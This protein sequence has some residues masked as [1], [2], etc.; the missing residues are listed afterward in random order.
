MHSGMLIG[1]KL[2][3]KKWIMS[4]IIGGKNDERIYNND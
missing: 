1:N 2:Q 3:N 4:G